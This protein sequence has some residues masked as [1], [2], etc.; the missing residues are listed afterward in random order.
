[1]G[2]EDKHALG[3]TQAEEM[4]Q[5][6]Q[7][8][9]SKDDLGYQ[10]MRAAFMLLAVGAVILILLFGLVVAENVWGGPS[11]TTTVEKSSS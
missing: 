4:H 5:S 7:N 2:R 8:K 1:M 11:E 9:A 10:G 6:A 3:E